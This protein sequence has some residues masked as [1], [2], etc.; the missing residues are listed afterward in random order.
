MSAYSFVDTTQSGGGNT[1]PA[2][3]V[4]YNGIWLDEEIEG[5]R[6][7][8]VQGRELMTQTI[9]SYN[10]GGVDGAQFRR[11]TLPT[12]TISVTYQLIARSANE[13]RDNFNRLNRLLMPQQAR[14]IFAD[15]QD[16]Y[17]IAT[18]AT[19]DPVE[20][21]KLAVTGKINF[22]CMD[23]RKWAVEL[24]EFPFDDEGGHNTAE[25]TND[26]TV[27]VPIS[28]RLRMPSTTENGFIG[29]V[30]DKGVMQ[31]GVQEEVDKEAKTASRCVFGIADIR[32]GANDPA[33]APKPNTKFVLNGTIGTTTAAES[34]WCCIGNTGSGDSW[35]GGQKTIDLLNNDQAQNFVVY[36]HH[37][38]QT[39]TINELGI[40][41]I[42][43]LD[44]NNQHVAGIN[45]FKNDASRN[46]AA[47]EMYA[48][49]KFQQSIVFTPANE[50][51][52]NKF[53]PS[54]G[55]CMIRKE[56]GKF[57]FYIGGKFYTFAVPE[58]AARKV[59]KVQMGFMNF[60]TAHGVTRNYIKQVDF[61]DLNATYWVDI[62]NR[63]QKNDLVEIMGK[64][65]KIYVNK[66]PR[67]G[68]EMTGTVYFPAEPG[69]NQVELFQSD[70]ADTVTG[71]AIIREAWL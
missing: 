52:D 68:D 56:S 9:E 21:G 32:A 50:G 12:R 71:K 8:Q 48:G 69:F 5:F 61:H 70:W 33:S 45:I 46:V 27:A 4:K 53:L 31:F 36:T 3:A 57:T 26:G 37:W 16:K 6:T 14:L 64:E 41:Y 19:C 11:A 38:F 47:C 30:S 29:L 18:R 2:E 1:L 60:G 43:F 39:A 49:G 66:I 40:Q 59:K 65:G 13:F 20:A 7:L 58:A 17:F 44:S 24:K 10:I 42:F 55:Q 54:T 62:K 22:T 67:N 25:I 51:S 15:E 23:P 34:L 35:H 28:Y 63:Y